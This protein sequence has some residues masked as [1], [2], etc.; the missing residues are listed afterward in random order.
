[1]AAETKAT[2]LSL[3]HHSRVSGVPKG[4]AMARCRHSADQVPCRCDDAALLARKVNRRH[5]DSLIY[6]F[7]DEF[8]TKNTVHPIISLDVL[9]TFYPLLVSDVDVCQYE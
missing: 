1:M 9:F 2:H 5:I 6:L 8:L 4:A 7:L 3:Q